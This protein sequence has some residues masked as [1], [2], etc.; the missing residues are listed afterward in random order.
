MPGTGYRSVSVR[1][2]VL[3]RL[4][5]IARELGARSVAEAVALVVEDWG[6]YVRPLRSKDGV[7][8]AVLRLLGIEERYL[9]YGLIESY[10]GASSYPLIY[11]TIEVS[12]E[13]SKLVIKP[14][15][16]LNPVAISNIYCYKDGRCS[17]ESLIRDVFNGIKYVEDKLKDILSVLN[18][19][20]KVSLAGKEEERSISD[21]LRIFGIEVET[22]PS[23][24]AIPYKPKT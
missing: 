8:R 10:F 1:E 7:V 3:R 4:E 2:E 13:S 15:I 23:L 9:R 12:E 6:R 11:L 18:V 19:K 20:T 5:E 24:K 17:Y 22:K 21:V 14:V 16:A